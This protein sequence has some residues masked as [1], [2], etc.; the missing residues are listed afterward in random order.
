MSP[1]RFFR[2]LFF[3]F[4]SWALLAGGAAP[5]A[6]HS[7]HKHKAPPVNLPEVTAQVNGAEIKKEVIL[8]ELQKTMDNYKSRGKTLS[9]DQLKTLAKKLIEEEIERTLLVQKGQEIGVS[10]SPEMVNRRLQ[11]IK[12]EFKSDAV[13]E[14][15]LADRGL[16]VDQYREELKNDLLL[17]QVIKREIEPRIQ[18]SENELRAY[19]AKHQDRF[20]TPDKVRARVILIKVPGQ[21]GPEAEHAAR[22]KIQ[23]IRQRVLNGTDFAA[24]AQKFSQD[25]LRSKGGD[26]GYFT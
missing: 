13:F 21:G 25:S 10:A 9:P 20:R 1:F 26:L 7:G 3:L 22:K 8:R 17:D 11:Q 16:T 14:H 2:S 23:S 24:M 4:L 5:V 6:A 12:A 15:R 18:I 19:Y